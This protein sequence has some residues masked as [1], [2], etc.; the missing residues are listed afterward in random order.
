MQTT[1]SSPRAHWAP[2]L[3]LGAVASAGLWLAGAHDIAGLGFVLAAVGREA[4]G[5][6][7]GGRCPRPA[8]R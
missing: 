1:P 8:P 4:P 2:T 5:G 6:R 3:V 7:T